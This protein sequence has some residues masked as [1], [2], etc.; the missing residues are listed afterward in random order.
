MGFCSATLLT[1]LLRF[2]SLK[3]SQLMEI[4]W[5]VDSIMSCVLYLMR[6]SSAVALHDISVLVSHHAVL[7][8]V[9]LRYALHGIA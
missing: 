7:N 8:R 1:L 2:A 4:L 6:S 3:H 9:V 5:L